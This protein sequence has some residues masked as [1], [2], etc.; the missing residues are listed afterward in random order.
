MDNKKYNNVGMDNK[1]SLN[2]EIHFWRNYNKKQK[3]TVIFNAHILLVEGSQA[4]IG[5]QLW[6]PNS[7]I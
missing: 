3:Q 7:S 6:C 1:L 2:F 5:V 4:Y